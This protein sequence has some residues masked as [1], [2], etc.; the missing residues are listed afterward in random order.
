MLG[1]L[2][3]LFILPHFNPM[4]SAIFKYNI[5]YIYIYIYIYIIIIS[6]RVF[7]FCILFLYSF[8]MHHANVCLTPGEPD[9]V[10]KWIR[11]NSDLPPSAQIQGNLLIIP[12]I[13]VQDGGIYR[14]VAHNLIGTV[15]AQVSIR[16]RG[17]SVTHCCLE[18]MSCD[19]LVFI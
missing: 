14:C 17:K 10:V 2:S 6:I 13:R 8:T 7:T 12:S 18:M 15:F 11:L 9:P 16:V 4:W 1:K 5:I 3:L 19:L